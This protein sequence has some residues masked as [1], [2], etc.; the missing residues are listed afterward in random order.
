MR[1]IGA[2]NPAHERKSAPEG[3]LLMLMLERS[4]A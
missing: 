1:G 2:T 4:V 3:A